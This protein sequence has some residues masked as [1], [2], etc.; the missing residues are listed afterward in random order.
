MLM[1]ENKVV[2]FYSYCTQ[3]ES[4]HTQTH[5]R[6]RTNSHT[7][8]VQIYVLLA[9]K[10]AYKLSGKGKATL[11]VLPSVSPPRLLNGFVEFFLISCKLQSTLQI[12]Q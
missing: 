12:E 6:E 2:K 5:P 9:K 7:Y 8:G 1:F 10:N 11:C 3:S 4:A